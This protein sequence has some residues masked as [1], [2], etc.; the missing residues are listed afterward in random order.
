M[1]LEKLPL[2]LGGFCFQGVNTDEGVQLQVIKA[3]LT[4]VTSPIV[5]VHERD[6]LLVVRTC[7]NIYMA[8]RN[9]VN[10]TTARATLTQMLNV[11]FQ[12]MEQATLDAAVQH[13]RKLSETKS[14]A[15]VATDGNEA[16]IGNHASDHEDTIFERKSDSSSSDGEKV[17]DGSVGQ[18]VMINEP[19]LSN[20][21][22]VETSQAGSIASKKDES[23][24]EENEEEDVNEECNSETQ[25]HAGS[26]SAEEKIDGQETKATSDE[27]SEDGISATTPN[28][29]E[30][31]PESVVD[32]A[33]AA[34]INGEETS[35]SNSIQP[36][37]S[38]RVEATNGSAADSSDE[39]A[40]SDFYFA[41]ISQKDAFLVFRSLCKLAMKPLAGTNPTDPKSHELRSKILSLQLLLS[42]LQQPGPADR[43]SVV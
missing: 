23:I 7:Y 24:E 39:I 16:G 32:A 20:V 18:E 28:D 38:L 41:H 40:S 13:D 37:V 33:E 31:E 15:E 4:I 43:K 5:E 6:I 22:Q 27:A 10:Q 42:I 2:K 19:A 1:K 34:S 3:L 14:E 9:L 8:T 11:I 21:D 26:H 17:E 36:S 12:R 30:G 35:K 29:G 25:S